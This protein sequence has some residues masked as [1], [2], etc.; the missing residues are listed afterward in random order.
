MSL[1]PREQEDN[2][3]RGFKSRENKVED[4]KKPTKIQPLDAGSTCTN[5]LFSQVVN[6]SPFGGS[7]FFF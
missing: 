4:L 1:K 5:L 3:Y 7:I 6:S 2:K